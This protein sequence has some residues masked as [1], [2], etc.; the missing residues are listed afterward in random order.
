MIK[1]VCLAMVLGVYRMLPVSAHSEECNAL[2]FDKIKLYTPMPV[3]QMYEVL[4]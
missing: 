3:V 2:V 4:Y 1:A